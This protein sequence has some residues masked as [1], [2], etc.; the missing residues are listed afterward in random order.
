MISISVEDCKVKKLQGLDLNPSPDWVAEIDFIV[1]TT[2][3]RQTNTVA[4]IMNVCN[5]TMTHVH[6]L[7][8]PCSYI[9]MFKVRQIN[10]CFDFL[11]M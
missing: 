4:E 1:Y 7:I 3:K 9:K 11:V 5:V 2:H 8:S 10:Y 6:E